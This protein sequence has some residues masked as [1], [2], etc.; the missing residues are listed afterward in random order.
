MTDRL[1]IGEKSNNINAKNVLRLR[2]FGSS[3]DADHRLIGLKC[4]LK[5]AL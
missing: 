2:K 3:I 5:K 1:Y 4:S